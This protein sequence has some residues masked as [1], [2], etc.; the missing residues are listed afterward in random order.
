MNDNAG[1]VEDELQIE[2]EE[3]REHTH[4]ISAGKYIEIP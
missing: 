1:K 3:S 4:E 2:H